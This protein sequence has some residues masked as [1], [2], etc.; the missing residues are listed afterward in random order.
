MIILTLIKQLLRGIDVPPGLVGM[1][2]GA[3]ESAVM[4]GF[5]ELI[6]LSPQVSWGSWAILVPI[7]ILVIRTGE[8]IADHIDP[9]KRRQPN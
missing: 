4:A 9:A 5:E 8:G 2:R 6:V 1:A 3:L 7:G